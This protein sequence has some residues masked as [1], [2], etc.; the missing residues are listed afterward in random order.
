M[1]PAVG[2]AMANKACI[3]WALRSD[4]DLVISTADDSKSTLSLAE[5]ICQ[6]AKHAAGIMEVSIA[7]YSLDQ[8]VDVSR[9]INKS[10]L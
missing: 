6:E 4:G 7:D 5:L 2:V 1:N 10:L 3:P 9:F 8:L